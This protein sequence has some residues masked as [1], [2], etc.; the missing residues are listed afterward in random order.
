MGEPLAPESIPAISFGHG[1]DDTEVS[2]PISPALP[3]LLLTGGMKEHD[4]E[5]LGKITARPP[6]GLRREDGASWA[7]DP[8]LEE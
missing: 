2:P 5:T 7:S 4:R 1:Q 3:R 8:I 6:A